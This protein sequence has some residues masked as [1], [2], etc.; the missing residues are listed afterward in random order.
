MRMLL[1]E[2]NE[3]D[4]ILIREVLANWKRRRNAI[5]EI[6]ARRQCRHRLDRPDPNWS[7]MNVRLD[8][9]GQPSISVSF[10]RRSSSGVHGLTKVVLRMSPGLAAVS[11]SDLG[12]DVNRLPIVTGASEACSAFPRA[13]QSRRSLSSQPYG[14]SSRDS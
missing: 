7:R 11:G 14:L 6:E 1:I 9:N 12:R 5:K 13:P 10:L 3:G 8:H 4:A 2:D